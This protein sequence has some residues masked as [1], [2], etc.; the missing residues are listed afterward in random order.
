MLKKLTRADNSKVNLFEDR[1]RRLRKKDLS[2]HP[3][4]SLVS[5]VHNQAADLHLCISHNPNINI[6]GIGTAK[7]SLKSQIKSFMETAE[8]C[9]LFDIKNSS[10]RLYKL[11]ITNKGYINTASDRMLKVDLSTYFK[12]SSGVA[13]HFRYSDAIDNA[14]CELSEH[15]SLMCLWFGKIAV[16]K[17]RLDSLPNNILMRLDTI[18]EHGFEIVISEMSLNKTG[19]HILVTLLKNNEILYFGSKCHPSLEDAI[20]GAILEVETYVYFNKIFTKHS[21]QNSMSDMN[22]LL[23]GKEIDYNHLNKNIDMLNF[24]NSSSGTWYAQDYTN[25]KFTTQ[26]IVRVMNL[27]YIPLIFDR[28]SLQ[29]H[30]N[31]IVKLSGKKSICTV[32]KSQPFS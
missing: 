12:S 14:V 13:A 23:D 29:T 18:H 31:K 32:G 6:F 22:F 11:S 20:I 25:N 4:I 15:D 19:S 2:S 26:K 28:I 1:L 17:I 21:K 8:R 30:Y 7:C 24:F 9:S 27:S 10:S 16:P 5:Q 3:L